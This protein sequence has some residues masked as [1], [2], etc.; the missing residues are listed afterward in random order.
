MNFLRRIWKALERDR[1]L[2]VW[3]VG[4]GLLFTGMGIVPPLLVGRMVRWVESGAAGRDFFLLGLVL[5]GVYLLRGATRYLYGLMSHIAAYRTLHRLTNQ[6]YQH[7]QRMPPAFV[8]R[9]H[10]GNLVA[11]SIGD[12]EAIE[13]FIAHGIPE[14]MLA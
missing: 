8:N 5:A 1:R 11:R 2:L 13:D 9:R 6:T 12:V 3:S 4:F 14:T 7:L 10:T